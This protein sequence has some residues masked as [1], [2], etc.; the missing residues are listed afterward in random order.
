MKK[1]TPLQSV[2][3]DFGSK[4]KL[5]SQLAAKLEKFEG[6]GNDDFNTRLTQVS[7]K[8]LLRLWK[9]QNR[10]ESE[11][12]SKGALVDAIVTLKNPKQ[13]NDRAFKSK[14][15]NFRATRLLDMHDSLNKNA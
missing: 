2:L 8:K 14:L 3:K 1:L 10:L 15:M 5:V 13:A 12:S 7:N 6:E 4:E 11:F 9:A